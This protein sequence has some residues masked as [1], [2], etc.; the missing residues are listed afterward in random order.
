VSTVSLESCE[1][2]D[3]DIPD[4]IAAA[5]IVT[6]SMGVAIEVTSSA[7][8]SSAARYLFIFFIS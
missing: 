5:L 3:S 7:K 4:S 8:H 1:L 2:S 6:K